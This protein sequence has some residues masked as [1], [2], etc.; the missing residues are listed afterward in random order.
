VTEFYFPADPCCRAIYE[1]DLRPFECWACGVES[2][3]PSSFHGSMS[4]YIFIY[5]FE[6][7]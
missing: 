3:R 1:V 4:N 5:N 6:Q 7:N 2:Q